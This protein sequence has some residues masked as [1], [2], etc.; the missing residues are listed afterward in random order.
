M[1]GIL[2]IGIATLDIINTTDGY[3]QEDDE[4]RALSQITRRG[5]NVTNTLTVLS[6]LGH[7]CD[8][9]GTLADDSDS[10][11]IQSELHR[12]GINT[13][14]CAVI[15]GG[16]APTSYITL[17]QNNG[18]RT[19]VHYRDLPEYGFQHFVT[20][21]G[22]HSLSGVQWLHM[23]GR[24]VADTVKILVF[25]RK[26]HPS[27]K[28]SI[29]IEK[30]RPQIEALYAHGDVVV[31]S[32]H[33]ANTLHFRDAGEFLRAW[34]PKCAAPVLVCPWGTEGAYAVD[35]DGLIHHA[36]AVQISHVVDTIGA[37]DTFNAGFIHAA[38]SHLSLPDS[39]HFANGLAGKKCG[40]RGFD[41]LVD[42]K[43]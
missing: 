31:F 25:V 7:Q 37:G 38:L 22:T 13:Q 26:H 41:N 20:A 35:H 33:F 34:R 8:W 6:Q 29:E 17:N 30:A 24:N 14:R 10:R 4:V 23:E 21:T 43:I 2:G 27:I 40:Q 32:R 28:I 11:V 5:G 12:Y 36:R 16:H 39:L 18:S 15:Q 19:I 3:P 1:A 42:K 9:A